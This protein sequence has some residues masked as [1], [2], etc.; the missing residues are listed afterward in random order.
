MKYQFLILITVVGFWVKDY[1]FAQIQSSAFDPLLDSE[2]EVINTVEGEQW[3]GTYMWYPG[4]LSA[5]MQNFQKQ[6]SEERCTY[7]GYPGKF[8]EA[9]F[10]SFFRK[11]VHLKQKGKPPPKY[12][13]R[14]PHG[15]IFHFCQT[16]FICRSSF[17]LL[18]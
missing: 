7:V 3:N 12:T 9:S 16:S 8:N 6:K 13:R 2:C 15:T 17:R 18:V 5:H 1:S 14:R 11:T 10:R 4:Q